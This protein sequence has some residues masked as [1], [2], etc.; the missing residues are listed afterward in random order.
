MRFFYE[1][2]MGD[3]GYFSEKDLVKA[4]YTAWNIEA[5]LYLLKDGIKKIDKYEPF[6]EQAKLVFTP[7]DGNELNSQLLE[8]FGYKMED[9]EEYREIVDIKTGKIIRYDWAEV[10]QLV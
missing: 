4:I 5:D 3:S 2:Y 1:N 7:H 8:E 9:G 10:K 6:R